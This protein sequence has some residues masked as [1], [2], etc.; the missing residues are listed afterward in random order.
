MASATSGILSG[1][2][3][4]ELASWTF[5]PAAGAVLADW[6]AEVLKIEHPAGGD[7]QRGLVSSGVV[8]GSTSGINHMIEQPNRGKR[9][10]A[11]DVRHPEGRELLYRLIESADVFLTNWLLEPCRRAGF[12]VDSIRARNPSI[13]YARGSGQGSRGPDANRGGFDLASYWARGGIGD[14]YFPGPGDYPPLQR[15]AFGDIM[16]GLAIAAGIAGALFRRE[17]TGEP[18]IVDVSLLGT[19]V[20][21]LAPDVVVSGLLGGPAPKFDLAEMPN[22]LANFYRTAD[23]RFL[24]F[25]LLQSD[26]H[27]PA[28]CAAIERLDLRDDVR[29]ASAAARSENR[30]VCIEELRKVFAT[31]TLAQWKLRLAALE[32]VW[33]PVQSAHELHQDEQVLANGYLPELSAENGARFR[34]AANPVQFDETPPS[35]RRAPGIGEDT[36]AVLLELGFEIERILELK[37]SGVLL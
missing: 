36:D 24:A 16:G 17:R 21:N 27:W 28:F 4:V 31:R 5:V 26:R 18:S 30:R 37:A 25:V 34:L 19:A 2:R 3:V 29:F 12:D 13:V 9:S 20:W 23:G 7:P 14:A 8:A 35:L 32:G 1:V 33:A 15:P 11:L 22:P 10:V 6:G